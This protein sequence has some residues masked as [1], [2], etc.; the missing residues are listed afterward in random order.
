LFLLQ[1]HLISSRTY[2]PPIKL[3][4]TERDSQGLHRQIDCRF[5][6]AI[7]PGGATGSHL[8]LTLLLLDLPVPFGPTSIV[9]NSRLLPAE[10][11]MFCPNP[12]VDTR[13]RSLLKIGC[14]HLADFNGLSHARMLEFDNA[15]RNLTDWIITRQGG[16]GD[17]HSGVLVARLRDI[18]RTFG[19][20]Y[21]DG[22]RDR[23]W[24]EDVMNGNLPM[25][26]RLRALLSDRRFWIFQAT[27][28]NHE[29]TLA[30]DTI[31]QL[32]QWRDIF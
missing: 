24:N 17:M 31:I 28:G 10:L 16:V 5:Q 7:F 13:L 32:C 21:D 12:E 19:L 20:Q 22:A 14:I 18:C 29:F 3:I 2:T 1:F 9:D 8:V 23:R 25:E 30:M 11:T 26:Q 6:L 15:I 27:H 4:L